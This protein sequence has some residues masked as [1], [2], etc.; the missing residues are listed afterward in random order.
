MSC[1]LLIAHVIMLVGLLLNLYGLYCDNL[2]PA[3][4]K[5]MSEWQGVTNIFI[6][7]YLITIILRLLH[8]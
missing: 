7:L 5:E 3:E 8:S 6:L 1:I 4:Q 2:K